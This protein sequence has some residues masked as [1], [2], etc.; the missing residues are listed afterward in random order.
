[1]LLGVIETPSAE[2]LTVREA[3]AALRVSVPTIRRYI[4]AG[5]LTAALRTFIRA[6]GRSAA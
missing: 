6:D 1:M 5:Q 4:A 3:A 2:L